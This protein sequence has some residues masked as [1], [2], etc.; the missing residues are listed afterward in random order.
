MA[1]KLDRALI[2]YATHPGGVPDR[3]SAALKSDFSSEE[4]TELA[5]RIRIL[6]AE[7]FAIPVDWSQ[8][9]LAEA[10]AVVEREFQRRHP[11]IDRSAVKALA[12]YWSFCNR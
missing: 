5:F 2:L 4:V 10:S 3:A 1:D 9:D 6:V 7:M 8:F 11:E 12:R